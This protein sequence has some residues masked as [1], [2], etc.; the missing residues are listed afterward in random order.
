VLGD[1]V[2]EHRAWLLTE[3]IKMLLSIVPAERN[4]KL[5]EEATAY[6]GHSLLDDEVPF[7]NTQYEV[8]STDDE[9]TTYDSVLSLEEQP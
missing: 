7:S 1:K 2:F 6:T 3:I 8:S 4:L 5:C 9:T